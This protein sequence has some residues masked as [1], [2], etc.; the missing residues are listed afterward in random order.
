MITLSIGVIDAELVP[1]TAASYS[2]ELYS[3]EEV[4]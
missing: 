4:I 1:Q 3:G 2:G